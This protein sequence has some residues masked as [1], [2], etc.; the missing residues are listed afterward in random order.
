MKFSDCVRYV[1]QTTNR[2]NLAD[3]HVENSQEIKTIA[4]YSAVLDSIT[5]NIQR[6]SKNPSHI[7]YVMYEEVVHA[8]E[9]RMNAKHGFFPY[10]LRFDPPHKDIELEFYISEI[11]QAFMDYI[12]CKYVVTSLGVSFNEPSMDEKFI[13]ERRS[14]IL[15]STV[16]AKLAKFSL[17]KLSRTTAKKYTDVKFSDVLMKLQSI[18]IASNYEDKFSCIKQMLLHSN[19]TKNVI[20]EKYSESEMVRNIGHVLPNFWKGSLKIIAINY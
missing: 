15:A 1:N 5:V 8:Y 17:D 13:Q 3:I 7:Q 12:A 2:L 20:I 16:L 19:V 11:I 14:G 9:A 6:L 4:K 18:G 10:L